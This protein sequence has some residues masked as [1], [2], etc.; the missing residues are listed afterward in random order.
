MSSV[1]FKAIYVRNTPL[2]S[3]FIAW[4]MLCTPIIAWILELSL[5]SKCMDK[6]SVSVHGPLTHSWSG[7]YL[8]GNGTRSRQ[9][10]SSSSQQS[11]QQL[12]CESAGRTRK[13]INNN[14]PTSIKWGEIWHALNKIPHIYRLK[15]WVFVVSLSERDV[16][17]VTAV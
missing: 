3:R 4:M 1:F 9:T 17:F 2:R 5:I 7:S 8:V 12:S 14:I 16:R 10:S 15:C 6:V 13:G 11:Q